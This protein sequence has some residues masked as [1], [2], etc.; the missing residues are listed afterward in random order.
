MILCAKNI[1]K[2]GY[3]MKKII[4]VPVIFL[5]LFFLLSFSSVKAK[6]DNSEYKINSQFISDKLKVKPNTFIMD[7]KKG[8]VNGDNIDDII[9]LLGYRRFGA[10]NPWSEDIKVVVKDGKNRKFRKISVGKMDYG[11]NGHIFLGD[12]NG[13]RTADIFVDILRGGQEG[14]VCCSL[15]SFKNNKQ[16]HI[17]NENKFIKGLAFDIDYVDDF[18]INIFNKDV[19]KSCLVNTS[20]KKNIYIEEKVYSDEGEVLKEREGF[21]GSFL[22]LK[23]VDADSDGVYELEGIQKLYGICK[24]DTIGYAKTLWKFEKDNMK[25]LKLNIIPYDKIESRKKKESV[26]PVAGMS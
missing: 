20:G 17:F 23:A 19:N 26:M 10:D 7:C 22:N 6:E 5:A 9:L 11:Y 15:I 12:F 14:E 25:L 21:S 13:D 3:T 1:S 8:D 4:I 18:K 2:E 24:A 16:S